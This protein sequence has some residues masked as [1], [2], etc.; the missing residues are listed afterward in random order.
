MPDATSDLVLRAPGHP[1]GRGWVLLAWALVMALC[2]IVLAT[3]RYSADMSAFLP[4]DPDARQ[5]LLIDQIRDG[6]LSRMVLIGI[7]GGTAAARAD[8]S[9]ALAAALRA[10]PEFRGVVNGDEAS[11]ERDQ[12][13]LLDNRYVLSPAVTPEH[14][15]VDGL[16]QAIGRSIAELSGSAGMMLRALL[17]RDPTGELVSALDALNGQGNR[18][19]NEGTW[20][21][22]DGRRAMLIAMTRA[23]GTD[24]DA[25]EQALNQL[26]QAFDKLN[27]GGALQLRMSGTP[28]FAVHARATIKSE[29][30]RLSLI[31][32]VAV[33]LLLFSVYRSL[34]NVLIGL[35]PVASGIVVAIA[36]VSLG[37]GVV[38]AITIGFGTTLIG[39]TI[40]Y[41]IYYLMQARDPTAWRTRY[42]PTI[43]LGVATSVCGFAVLMFSSFP[44]LAQL[45]AYSV[46]GLIA[47]AVIT[48]FVLPALPTAPVPQDRLERLGAIAAHLAKIMRRLRWPAAV[49]A[50][51]AIGVVLHGQDRLWAQ[52]LSGLN[53]APMDL[54]RLDNALR[55][56]AGAP[57]LQ[58]MVVVSAPTQEDALRGAEVIDRRL[59]PLVAKGVLGGIETPTRVLPSTAMQA[60]RRAALP[61]P[62]VLQERLAS[63]LEGLPL[64]PE[65]L[66]PFVQDVARARKSPDV[67]PSTLEGSSLGFMVSTL[68]LQRPDGWS[69]LMPLRLNEGTA[70]AQAGAAPAALAPLLAQPL[71]G[72]DAFYLN[73]QEQATSVFGR[74]LDEALWLAAIGGLAITALLAIALRRP[75]RVARVMLPLAGAVALV[76]AAHVL[77]GVRLTLLH[78]VGLLLIVGVGSNY[79]LFFNQRVAPTDGSTDGTAPPERTALA[80]LVLA[81]VST[82]IGFGILG[83][84]QVPVLHAIGATVGPGALLALL[85]AM[86]WSPRPPAVA[87]GRELP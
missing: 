72:A 12:A 37:F 77:L 42:W 17:P 45:G 64:R 51:C 9:R 26:G 22:A 53:P 75:A 46:A 50:V 28:V 33:F 18:S 16:R 84:S 24:T 62:E 21:S 40:D 59:A 6:A 5:R 79:A 67:T 48:R 27:A 73:L 43:R 34:R 30:E 38:H 19:S 1:R 68:L 13:L 44:G 87:H 29:V 65:R 58:H 78:L 81:N 56:D 76:M 3:S 49:L 31:G 41:S 10:S 23:S 55:Q 2:A 83:F 15:S 7:D 14:F 36:A 54:Q 82:L 69:V 60:E 74:Y 57:D 80:S 32:S 47:A 85:L 86:A 20:A 39:E 61:S 52:G 70:K 35:L 63:A 71:P 11:R 66:A 4:R 25:Q 8:A